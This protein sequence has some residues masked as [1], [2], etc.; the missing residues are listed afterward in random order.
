MDAILGRLDP[1]QLRQFC[2]DAVEQELR[3]AHELLNKA[4]VA[5]KRLEEV[6]DAARRL[7][8]E[9]FDDEDALRR[10]LHE[11][12]NVHH[13]VGLSLARIQCAKASDDALH[14]VGGAAAAASEHQRCDSPTTTIK[15]EPFTSAPPVTG[16]REFAQ[17]ID[18]CDDSEDSETD[19]ASDASESEASVVS[20]DLV[21]EEPIAPPSEFTASDAEGDDEPTEP[22]A[23]PKRP[24]KRRLSEVSDVHDA[25]TDAQ[26]SA[27]VSGRKKEL[28]TEFV[29]QLE[30]N[31]LRSAYQMELLTTAKSVLP[32]M[33]KLMKDRGAAWEELSG[34][35][36][37]VLA[38]AKSRGHEHT[39]IEKGV[40]VIVVDFSMQVLTK[41]QPE[42]R[43]KSLRQ[44][45][46]SMAAADATTGL[47][48]KYVHAFSIG[49]GSQGPLFS[50][51][52]CVNT[53]AWPF[54][55]S[56]ST[57]SS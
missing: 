21:D 8:F 19:S 6:Q 56:T 26:S 39:D 14:I 35:L 57:S 27:V 47:L 11:L 22:A 41:C 50:L 13:S 12:H 9:V 15:S 33:R 36:K 1:R 49:T 17:A 5:T 44:L 3:K 54:S 48:T 28:L 4:L 2:V 43:R 34:K 32:L 25:C 42:V 24:R 40:L 38:C 55:K 53:G 30:S 10:G 20:L 51:S 31:S 18:L 7:R 52:C 23:R 16:E 46:K 37:A 45:L 29:A